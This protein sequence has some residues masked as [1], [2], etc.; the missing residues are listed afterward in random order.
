MNDD[1]ET[2][3]IALALSGGGIRAAVFHLGVI[4][5]LAEAKLL[6]EIKQ[7]STVSGGSLVTGAI[8]ASPDR[9]NSS[10]TS[11]RPSEI[12]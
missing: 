1:I 5:R 2:P 3:R 10:P 12:R 6:E 7:I 11:I 8:F 9:T 4:R